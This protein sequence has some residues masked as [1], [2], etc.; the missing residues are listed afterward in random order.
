MGTKVSKGVHEEQEDFND[1]EA[2]D[3]AVDSSKP[4]KKGL[5][6]WGLV[7]VCLDHLRAAAAEKSSSIHTQ[8]QYITQ[9]FRTALTLD[10]ELSIVS[11]NQFISNQSQ[12]DVA[13]R[14]KNSNNFSTLQDLP[15]CFAEIEAIITEIPPRSAKKTLKDC[16]TTLWFISCGVFGEEPPPARPLVR[17]AN[18]AASANANAI[19]TPVA[20]APE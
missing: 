14:I 18:L 10:L 11:T 15:Q 7:D 8:H 16:G 17:R 13:A 6:W 12:E 4:K 20:V 9:V 1:C 19:P 5:S 2:E 3:N